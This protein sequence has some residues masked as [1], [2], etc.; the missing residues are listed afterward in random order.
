MLTRTNGLALK[1]HVLKC[2]GMKSQDDTTYFQMIRG[3]NVHI[4]GKSWRD[5]VR[6]NAA[7]C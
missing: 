7:N 1:R 4:Y 2:L 6:E 3:E 5:R